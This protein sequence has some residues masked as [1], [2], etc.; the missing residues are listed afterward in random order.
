[1]KEEFDR[2]GFIVIKDFWPEP[3]LEKF[4]GAVRRCYALQAGKIGMKHDAISVIAEFLE[5]QDKEAAH[6][7]SRMVELTPA[8]RFLSSYPDLLNTA[9]D[10]IGCAQTDLFVS[11]P[12][13][14]INSPSV[15]RLL[16]RW[17]AEEAY[18]PKRRNFLNVWFPIFEDKTS[19]NGTMHVLKGSHLISGRPFIEYQG[20]TN[21]FVQYEIPKEDLVE[22]ENVPIVAKRGD[23][24]LFHR[25]LVHSSTRN[26]SNRASYAGILRIL[27]YRKDLTLSAD[28]AAIPY[29]IRGGS[30]YGRPGLRV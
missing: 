26:I 29:A 25:N 6:Q 28:P 5:S 1:M 11:G 21:H 3:I 9:A 30:D 14:L 7:A 13:P 15:D 8:A 27:D 4:E 22:Y 17:H 16:Y 10:L 2:D 23:L 19:E 20:G 12:Q 18:Y 24:V